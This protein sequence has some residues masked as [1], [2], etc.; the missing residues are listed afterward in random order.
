[1]DEISSGY[2][3]TIRILTPANADVLATFSVGAQ[4]KSQ[5]FDAVRREIIRAHGA[6]DLQLEHGRQPHETPWVTTS[7]LHALDLYRQATE[8]MDQVPVKADPAFELLTR[9]H[10]H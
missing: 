2:V 9:G 10:P 1:M 4:T 8:L 5:L 3:A 6:V 7:S